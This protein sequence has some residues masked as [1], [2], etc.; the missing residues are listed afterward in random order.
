MV[1]PE[2]IG[3]VSLVAALEGARREQLSRVAAD[4]GLQSGGIASHPRHA[5]P[6]GSGRGSPH[7]GRSCFGHRVDPASTELRRFLDRNEV[8]FEWLSSETPA[9]MQR[10]DG[11]PLPDRDM[12][13]IR[14]GRRQDG[15]PTSAA[16]RRR[17]RAGEAPGSQAGTSSRGR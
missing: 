13:V 3:Q 8:T 16:T 15:D 12:P 1:T 14:V 7:R 6:A 10:W 11:S 17:R 4:I 5:R 9:M 2:E